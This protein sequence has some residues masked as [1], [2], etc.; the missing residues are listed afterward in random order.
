MQT[1]I[2]ELVN[3]IEQSLINIYTER[4]FIDDIKSGMPYDELRE[5]YY[6]TAYQYGATNFTL[7]E[8]LQ[9]L[10]IYDRNTA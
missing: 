8:G 3:K 6:T 9:V 1:E 7:D 10:Y 2:L 4:E 5:R